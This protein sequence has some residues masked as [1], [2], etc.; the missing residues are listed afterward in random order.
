[1]ILQVV[2]FIEKRKQTRQ[3]RDNTF[4]YGDYFKKSESLND[5]GIT[6]NY[7][8]RRNESMHS[9]LRNSDLEMGALRLSSG[10]SKQKNNSYVKASV[11]G[12]NNVAND[13]FI[14][15]YLKH[16]VAQIGLFKNTRIEIVV[17]GDPSLVVGKTV[18]FTH[19][20]VGENRIADPYLSGKYLITAL[21]HSIKTDTYITLLELSKDSVGAP[22]P[23]FDNSDTLL[24]S[25]V[26]GKQ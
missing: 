6:N 16:R 14:E 18:A 10:N 15:T 22:Y 26:K 9:V 24:D 7:K 11:G 2:S 8:N 3:K 1:M 12:A 19:F 5:H 23:Q 25:F 13:I 20:G 4:S 17:P 21:R